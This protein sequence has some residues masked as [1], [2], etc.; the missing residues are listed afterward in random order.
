[1]QVIADQ[2]TLLRRGHRQRDARRCAALVKE[3]FDSVTSRTRAQAKAACDLLVRLA[4]QNADEHAPLTIAKGNAPHP[5][6]D[7]GRIATI[8]V[9]AGSANVDGPEGTRLAG[10]ETHMRV[11][12]QYG[13]TEL[14]RG[15]L[16]SGRQTM[17]KHS[18]GRST[19]A[20]A[21]A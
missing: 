7:G 12:L 11:H 17:S 16:S 13:S 4:V 8:R 1:M 2:H 19:D 14:L 6:A 15:G 18:D 9:G 21:I 20:D 10:R 3:R 5:H